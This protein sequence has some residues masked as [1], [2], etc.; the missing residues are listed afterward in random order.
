MDRPE[1]EKIAAVLV[2]PEGA[3]EPLRK[4]TSAADAPSSLANGPSRF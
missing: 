1:F 4:V 2:G 3:L